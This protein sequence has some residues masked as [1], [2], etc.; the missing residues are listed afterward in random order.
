MNIGKCPVR[1]LTIA[2]RCAL[3]KASSLV[4][5]LRSTLGQNDLAV[6]QKL[7]VDQCQLTTREVHRSITRKQNDN[8]DPIRPHSDVSEIRVPPLDNSSALQS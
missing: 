3:L 8:G 4:D 2:A 1:T 6:P 5:L 7:V